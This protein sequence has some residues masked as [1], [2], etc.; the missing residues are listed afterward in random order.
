MP[1]EAVIP[2]LIAHAAADEVRGLPRRPDDGLA[3]R[4]V[5]LGF[6]QPAGLDQRRA[7]VQDGVK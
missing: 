4:Y 5:D 6:V 7:L 3:A 1:T 2:K